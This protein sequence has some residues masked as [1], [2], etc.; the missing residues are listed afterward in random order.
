MGEVHVIEA[1]PSPNEART[2][3]A[4]A[5]QRGALRAGLQGR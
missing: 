2:A 4:A 1:P 5:K 3:D